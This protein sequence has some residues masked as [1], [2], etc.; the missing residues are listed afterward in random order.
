MPMIIFS[1]L[2]ISQTRSKSLL[3]QHGNK[4]GWS[5]LKLERSRKI[6]LYWIK[7]ACFLQKY[8][9][10]IAGTLISI[11]IRRPIILKLF[12]LSFL[13]FFSTNWSSSTTDIALV[14]KIVSSPVLSRKLHRNERANLWEGQTGRN[15]DRNHERWAWGNNCAKF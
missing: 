14:Y 6:F 8:E 2:I 9:L 11:I 15:V 12:I 3:V 5:L 4:H 13:T 7:E 1:H 10:Q